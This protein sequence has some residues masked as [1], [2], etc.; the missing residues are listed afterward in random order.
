[1]SFQLQLPSSE[2][3][4]HLKLNIGVV[5][6]RAILP[7]L[8]NVLIKVQNGEITFTTTDSE[9]EVTTTIIPPESDMLQQE[10]ESITIPA[11]KLMDI[12]GSLDGDISITLDGD[13]AIIKGKRS[14]FKLH[15]LPALEFPDTPPITSENHVRIEVGM[16]KEIFT[17]TLECTGNNDVRYYLNGV[18]L[19]LENNMMYIVGTDGHRMAYQ[20]VELECVDFKVIVP[21]KAIMEFSKIFSKGIVDVSMD[22]N[23]VKFNQDGTTLISKLI[24]GDFPD[25]QNVIPSAVERMME[26]ETAE[27]VAALSRVSILSNEKYKGV[28]FNLTNNQLVISAKNSYQE[29][30]REVLAVEYTGDEME[31]GFNGVYLQAALKPLGKTCQ[32]HLADGNTS[33]LFMNPGD[34]SLKMIVMPMRL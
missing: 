32:L 31:I 6:P 17:N 10:T 14:K 16:L 8:G 26:V 23:H 21:R 29:T 15:T 19:Q 34:E 20:K 7:I 28:Q 9:V 18:L 13:E 5:A 4:Q 3:A 1:M 30:A 27:L 12:A 24:D 33:G 11:K 22:D 2:L 25:W